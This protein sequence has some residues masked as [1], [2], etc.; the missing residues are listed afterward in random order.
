MKFYEKYVLFSS[1]PYLL[2]GYESLKE[3]FMAFL[4]TNND[5]AFAKD[6]GFFKNYIMVIN[7]KLSNFSIMLFFTNVLISG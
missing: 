4:W 6:S 5:T 7:I 1:S 3:G 2:T